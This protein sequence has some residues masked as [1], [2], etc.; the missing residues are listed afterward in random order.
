MRDNFIV[1]NQFEGAPYQK[2]NDLETV[3]DKLILFR[4]VCFL[5]GKAYYYFV[6]YVFMLL[7]LLFCHR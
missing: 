3:K 6:S 7:R 4:A 5:P 1:L 2:T